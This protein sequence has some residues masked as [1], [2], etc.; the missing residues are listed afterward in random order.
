M[1]SSQ[2]AV[3][4]ARSRLRVHN[5]PAACSHDLVCIAASIY[6]NSLEPSHSHVN[7]IRVHNDPAAC[8]RDLVRIVYSILLLLFGSLA[9][10]QMLRCCLYPKLLYPV[11]AGRRFAL[12]ASSALHASFA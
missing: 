3:D 1:L 11:F 7:S 6:R 12:H 10:L 9:P 8:S 5:D 4:F 2:R